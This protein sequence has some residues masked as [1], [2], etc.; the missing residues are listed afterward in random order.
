MYFSF[1]IYYITGVVFHSGAV[2]NHVLPYSAM[3]NENVI[4]TKNII[5]FASK[6]T[7]KARLNFISTISCIPNVQSSAS[8]KEELEYPDNNLF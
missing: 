6:S 8:P 3:R 1:L 4:G 2:V 7:H 5:E